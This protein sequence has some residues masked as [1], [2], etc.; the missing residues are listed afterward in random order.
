MEVSS[1]PGGVGTGRGA[2]GGG[3]RGPGMANDTQALDDL[4]SN[5]SLDLSN[6]LDHYFVLYE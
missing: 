1:G 5:I 6:I 2:S 3:M 4:N